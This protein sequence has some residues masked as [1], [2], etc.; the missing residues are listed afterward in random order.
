M[1]V[2]LGTDGADLQAALPELTRDFKNPERGQ[3]GPI[4]GRTGR[5]EEQKH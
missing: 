1:S 4:W 5:A 3:E 2:T